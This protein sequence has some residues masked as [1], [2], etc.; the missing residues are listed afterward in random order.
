MRKVTLVCLVAVFMFF[1]GCARKPSDETVAQNIQ[2]KVSADPQAQ[3]SQVKVEAKEGKVTLKGTAKSNAV[4]QKIE[5]IAKEEPGVTEVDDRLFIETGEM[6]PA[7][8]QIAPAVEQAADRA[9]VPP[10]PPPLPKPVVV[11]AGTVFTIRTAQA[12]GS[13]TSQVGTAFTGSLSTPISIEGKMVI[14]AGS[15]VTGTV[16]EAKKA[17]RFKG[18]AV[19]GLALHSITVNGHQYNIETEAFQQT[20]TGKGKRTA[21]A[22]AGGAGAG[23]AIGGLAGGGKG[24]GIGALV[25]ATA[26]TIGAATT[27]NRDINLPAESALSF[28]LVQPLTLK[29][30]S[31]D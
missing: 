17:G 21:G 31:H 3:D 15:G 26:G 16:K 4:R 13:K 1:A 27:G 20:S 24:A 5:T 9:P 8:N 2:T 7:P 30:A 6:G 28:R 14:P 23:A 22:V 29:P 12:L 10:P 18:G 25:G 11:P 19:L